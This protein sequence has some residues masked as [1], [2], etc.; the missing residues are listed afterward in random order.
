M[1]AAGNDFVLIHAD[2]LEDADLESVARH[3]SCRR[4]SIGSD[5]LLVLSQV[6]NGIKLRMFNPDG[7]EDFCGNGARCAALHAL[8]EGWVGNKF[9]IEHL[10]IT[11]PATVS[12]DDQVTVTLPPPSLLFA[13]VPYLPDAGDLAGEEVKVQGV[14]GTPISTGSTHF[15]VFRSYAIPD[16][17]FLR[18]SPALETDPHFPDR[19]SIMWTRILSEGQISLR[20]WERGAGET[21][22]CGTGSSAAAVVYAKQSGYSRP[23]DVHNPGGTIRIELAATGEIA[24]TSTPVEVYKGQVDLSASLTSLAGSR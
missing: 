22:G 9:T 15:I 17:E 13:D 6:P 11:V 20:I 21:L 18:V 12:R 14:K 1:Q 4:F 19:T 3:V 24:M 8:R 2:D 5:G 7:S 23:I 16:E 10:G